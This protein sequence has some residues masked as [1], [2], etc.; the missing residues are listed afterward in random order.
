[1]AKPGAKEPEV[2]SRA[3]HY[4][5]SVEEIFD[6]CDVA[7]LAMDCHD[8]FRSAK[9]PIAPWRMSRSAL[10]RRSLPYKGSKHHGGLHFADL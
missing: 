3:V 5:R 6:H 9:N 2:C 4:G 7:V 8:Y 1:L 10:Q